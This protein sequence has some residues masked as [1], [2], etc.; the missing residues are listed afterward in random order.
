MQYV[1][2]ISISYSTNIFLFGCNLKKKGDWCRENLPTTNAM[3]ENAIILFEFIFLSVLNSTIGIFHWENFLISN[4]QPTY[5]V[6]SIYK[7]VSSKLTGIT[8]LRTTSFASVKNLRWFCI[9]VYCCMFKYVYIH[10]IV[11]IAII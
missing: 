4:R 8:Y 9:P 7:T 1:C 10:L 6:H 3:L 2:L 11:H 5:I